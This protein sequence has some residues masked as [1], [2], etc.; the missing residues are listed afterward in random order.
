VR[1]LLTGA[2]GLVGRHIATLAAGDGDVELIAT[3]RTRPPAL[4]AAVR[5]VPADLTDA[6][7]AAAIVRS[8]QPTHIVHAAW[9][10]RQP[11]YW[12]DM[13]NLDWIVSTTRMAEA[14]AAI[15]GERFVQ[16]GSCAEYDWSQ[17]LCIED[18]TPS[19]PATRYGR[20]K[21]AAFAAI[22]AA[23]LGRFEAVEGRIFM[24]FGPG[25]D[26]L[27]FIP[28]ICRAHLAGTVPELGSGAQRRDILYA[29]DAAQAILRLA[30]ARGVTGV[31]NIGAG[32]PVRLS[33]AARRL[34]DIAGASQTG[35]CARADRPGD[36]E[37]LVAAADRLRA[38]GWQPSYSL[39]DA[40]AETYQ[41]WSMEEHQRKGEK[42]G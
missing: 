21:L 16:L 25:E 7:A 30:K 20:A 22:E 15:G 36:P 26:P 2:S 18:V 37:I 40:L 14:F 4:D 23:A 34:A 19:R 8:T 42:A 38:I 24:V 27:R 31:V 9:E 10:T 35:L 12:D 17:G 6:D 39:D 32:E 33:D 28:A 13:A 41:W 5:F 3:G 11:T 1:L 29:K